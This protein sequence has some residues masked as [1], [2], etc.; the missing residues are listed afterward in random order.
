MGIR[1]TAR[2]LRL[3]IERIPR[4]LRSG[5]FRIA[6][7][8][9][10]ERH[11]LVGAPDLWKKQREFQID[12]LRRQGLLPHHK[13]V[14]VGCGTLRG[15]IP[16]IDYLDEGSYYGV[17]GSEAYLEEA[18]REAERHG[19]IAKRPTLL[20]TTDFNDIDCD[21]KFDYA[22]SFAVLLH[23]DDETLNASIKWV[24]EHLKPAGTFLADARVGERIDKI[25]PRGWPGVTRPQAFYESVAEAHGLQIESLGTNAS[26]GHHTGDMADDR[27]MFR[28]TPQAEPVDR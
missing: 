8:E 28:W 20:P 23:L 13:L 24:A 9:S 6:D 19:L 4:R 18:R 10:F 2:K 22:W 12:F 27:I 3:R 1:L 25:G 5:I 7:R 16:L 26:L 17:D 21:T 14:D 11:G 15:G